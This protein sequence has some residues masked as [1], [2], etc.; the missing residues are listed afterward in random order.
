MQ[1]LIKQNI[2]FEILKGECEM[3]IA[4]EYHGFMIVEE[5]GDYLVYGVSSKTIRHGFV[6]AFPTANEAEQFINFN[7]DNSD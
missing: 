6:R 4:Y 1:L 2:N 3:K 5:Y 7:F